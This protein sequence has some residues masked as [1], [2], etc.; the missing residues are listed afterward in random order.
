MLK[1]NQPMLLERMGKMQSATDVA[2]Y[3]KYD[4]FDGLKRAISL[5]DEEIL[6]ELDVAHLRGRGG[7][8]YPLGKK[9]RHLYHAKGTTKYIVCNADEG[10]PGTFKDKVLLSEDPLS[11]IEGMIIAGYLFSAKA[12]YI[13]MRGE[14][15]RIQKTFQEALDNAR[16]AGFLGENILGIEGFNYDITIISGAGAYI[17][18]E[19]SALL[20]SIE[21]KTGQ[22]R[23]KPPHLADVG[24][25][26]QPTLVNN[27]ESFASVPIIYEKV[28]KPF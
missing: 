13:Y 28:D 5:S 3:C 1:R 8:A 15:R 9:W 11:V 2:E 26:L 7:A 17:C 22:P 25:Y 14:Y 18:G 6:N 21:G 4:G 19:N 12:G 27:V 23:V 20:N 16:Q 10:E 24:L